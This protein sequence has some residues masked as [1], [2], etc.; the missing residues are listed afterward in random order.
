VEPCTC[1]FFCVT[2]ETGGTLPPADKANVFVPAV[3]ILA[4]AVFIVAGL[5]VQEVPSYSSVAL[6]TGS[7]PPNAKVAV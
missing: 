4:I 5:V 2:A 6:E 3:A 7:L 1:P